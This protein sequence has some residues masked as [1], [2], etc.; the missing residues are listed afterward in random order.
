[1]DVLFESAA[2]VYGER[3]LGIVLTGASHDGAAGA[4]A[5]ERAGGT[6]VVQRPDSAQSPAMAEAA[7]RRVPAAARLA[8]G[9]I[10]ELLRG[11]HPGEER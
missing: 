6:V 1:V 2:D 3:L 5:I 4:E 11:V 8:L 10:A 9:E 7:L